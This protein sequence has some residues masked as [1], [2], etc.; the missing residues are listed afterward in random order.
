M[1][2]SAGATGGS[3]AISGSGAVTAG[4]ASATGST[5][6]TTAGSKSTGSLRLDWRGRQIR[7]PTAASR[8]SA[9]NSV[10]AA[11]AIQSEGRSACAG[12]GALAAVTGASDA[13]AGW[14]VGVAA[15]EGEVTSACWPAARVAAGVRVGPFIGGE[16]ARLGAARGAAFV[17]GVA[18]G[19]ALFCGLVVGSG[20]GRTTGAWGSTGPAGRAV[21]LGVP[22]GK[23]KTSCAKTGAAANARPTATLA[24][25]TP[26]P[27]F[28]A[29]NPSLVR[30]A[31][32]QRP[33]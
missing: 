13:V 6:A 17:A 24:R 21:G 14:T 7:R 19:A 31:G 25:T 9:P 29:I 20:W 22:A 28:T 30:A 5:T 32:T 10:P 15:A 27:V 23:L 1:C 16:A 11:K 33:E 12:A 18:V 4:A 26:E 2:K 8:T 3:G